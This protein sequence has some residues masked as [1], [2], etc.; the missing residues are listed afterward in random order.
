M[1]GAAQS[2]RKS[3]D[4][5]KCDPLIIDAYEPLVLNNPH[6]RATGQ[7]LLD[8][9]VYNWNLLWWYLQSQSASCFLRIYR[10]ASILDRVE[11]LLYLIC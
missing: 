6:F 2:F 1:N 11:I 9:R 3:L 10:G 4:I 8:E 7:P 5:L